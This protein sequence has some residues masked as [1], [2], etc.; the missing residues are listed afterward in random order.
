MAAKSVDEMVTER[1]ISQ[2]EKGIVPWEK[3]W[4]GIS[5][6]VGQN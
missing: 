6:R 4:T 2:L 5:V 1:I 3:P